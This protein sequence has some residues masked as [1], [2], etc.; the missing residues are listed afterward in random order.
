VTAVGDIIEMN[1]YQGSLWQI[2]KIDEPPTRATHPLNSWVAAQGLNPIWAIQHRLIGFVQPPSIHMHLFC[3][4]LGRDWGDYPIKVSLWEADPRMFPVCEMVALILYA[5]WE[6]PSFEPEWSEY[7]LWEERI[8]PP[9]CYDVP[10]RFHRKR[11][12]RAA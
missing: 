1:Y 12:L 3:P 2:V 4:A 8:D 7:Y 11:R 6:A 9:N 10:R 5:K